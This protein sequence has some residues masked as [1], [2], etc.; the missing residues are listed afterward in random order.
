MI[1]EMRTY[2]PSPGKMQALQERFRN[3]TIGLFEKHGLK[4]VGFWTPAVGGWT[5]RLIYLLAFENM[6]QRDKAWADF[7]SDPEWRRVV[8]ESEKDGP[9]TARINN[10]IWR[11]TSYSPLR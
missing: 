2:E 5:N 1:Y 9:L 8:A 7:G 10:E 3:H 6:E 4:V 11:P